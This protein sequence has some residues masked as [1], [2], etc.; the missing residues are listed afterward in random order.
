MRGGLVTKPARSKRCSY[1]NA[2]LPVREKIDIMISAADCSELFRGHRFQIA[3]WFNLPRQVF[4]QLMLD[5]RFAFA[6]DPKR[7][8]AH[9]VVHDLV[10]L[11]GD[12]RSLGVSQNGEIAARDVEPNATQRDF[13]FV[14]DNTADWLGVAFVTIG[15]QHT[16]FA[17]RCDARLNLLER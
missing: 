16:A 7:N 6:P 1:P 8:V 13:I 3:E 4:K 14:S 11:R 2:I 17:A 5:A 10:D 12:V 15:A 9:H